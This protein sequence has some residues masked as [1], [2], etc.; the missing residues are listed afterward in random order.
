MRSVNVVGSLIVSLSMLSVSAMACERPS[1]PNMPDLDS[2]T[3]AEVMLASKQVKQFLKASNE[4]MGCTRS[5][6][7][8]KKMA[9]EMNEMIYQYNE[10]AFTYKA[11][12][13]TS[14][15]IAVR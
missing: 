1:S 12:S 13:V 2:A 4:Y 9:D 8:Y 11:R 5:N 7:R 14:K 3:H 6:K 15:S 10:L